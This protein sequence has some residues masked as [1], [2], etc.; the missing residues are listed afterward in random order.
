MTIALTE[1]ELRTQLTQGLD[2]LNR[3][4]LLMTYQFISCLIAEE[5]VNNV[6]QNWASGK[7]N[8]ETIQRAVASYHSKSV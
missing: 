3:E 4:Q 8:R 2:K 1:E 6:T 7:V 5:L